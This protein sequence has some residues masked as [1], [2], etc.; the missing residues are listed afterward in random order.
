[1][2]LLTQLNASFHICNTSTT[3]PQMYNSLIRLVTTGTAYKPTPIFY[4][5]SKGSNPY[6]DSVTLTMVCVDNKATVDTTNTN[7]IYWKATLSDS[8]QGIQMYVYSDLYQSLLGGLSFTA[9]YTSIILVVAGFIRG[10]LA[11]NLPLI[12]Y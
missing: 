11:G 8:K 2:P 6:L 5:D 10:F 4:T 3:I 9:I 12:P 1:L 7:D